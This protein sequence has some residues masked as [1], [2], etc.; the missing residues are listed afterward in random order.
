VPVPA[1][2]ARVVD[3]TATLSPEQRQALETQLAALEARKGVQL[4]VLIV[5]TTGSDTI[6]QFATRVYDQWKL[7]RQ[8][9]DD[10]VLFVVAKD[11]RTLR[12]EVG[13][14]LEGAVPDVMAGRIIREQVVP[15]FKQHDYAGGIG[16]GVNALIGLIDGESL[17]APAAREADNGDTHAS[18]PPGEA[19]GLLV[20][21]AL[22]PPILSAVLGG[23]AIGYISG[24]IL[25]GLLAALLAWVLSFVLGVTGLKK[26]LMRGGF[27]GGGGRGG[28]GFGGGGGGFRGGGGRSGGGGASGRW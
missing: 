22:A 23:V 24:S 6:E 3:Q 21:A 5:P 10:G 12:F 25:W 20:V 17:P 11:D 15:H 14:G 26:A 27:R 2:T 8:K 13:Y 4:A 16:A 1:L 7:G 19:L 18:G 28:G 9:V